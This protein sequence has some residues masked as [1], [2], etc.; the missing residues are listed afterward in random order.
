MPSDAAQDPVPPLLGVILAGGRSRRFKGADKCLQILAG[1]SLLD[2]TFER[3]KMQTG[4]VIISIAG[5]A[6]R[7]A[8]IDAPIIADDIPG[9]QGPLAGVAAAMAWLARHRPEIQWLASFPVDGPFFPGDLVARLSVHAIP[10]NAPAIAA[11][12]GRAHPVYGLWP[13]HIEPALRQYLAKSERCRLVDFVRRLG[14]IEVT[15]AEA[16]PDPFFNINTAEDL[17]RAETLIAGI[18]ENAPPDASTR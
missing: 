16:E 14:G 2:R 15:F 5:D 11:S 8:A 4:D 18:E 13:R 12:G 9:H 3:V 10:G 6:S 1:R 17:A 7:F